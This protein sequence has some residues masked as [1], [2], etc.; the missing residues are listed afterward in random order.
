MILGTASNTHIPILSTDPGLVATAAI[1]TVTCLL[2]F[3]MLI[4]K[5]SPDCFAPLMIGLLVSDFIY[6][7]PKSIVAF[8]FLLGNFF[9][10]A[11]IIILEAGKCLSFAFSALFAY[12]FYLLTKTA[13]GGSIV[14][15]KM[16][17]FFIGAIIPAVL[18]GLL[19]QVA[20][21]ETYDNEKHEYI[22]N[23]S[24]E[25]P[26]LIDFQYILFSI[27]P[28]V[29]ATI[30]NICFMVYG[31]VSLRKKHLTWRDWSSM[32]LYPGMILVCWLPLFV[33]FALTRLEA[34]S[35]S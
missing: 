18:W 8:S 10:Q 9:C 4:I 15:Q 7:L 23:I 3:I 33:V 20:S 27:I 32:L 11:A 21:Y 22:R 14:M 2:T 12:A 29:L 31:V 6:F 28:M 5:R 24:E 16:R 35:H 17:T 19:T 25:D 26:G 34:N 13:D 30:V 1:S